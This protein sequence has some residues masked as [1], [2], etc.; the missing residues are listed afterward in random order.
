MDEIT[1]RRLIHQNPELAFEEHNTQRLIVEF[2][3]ELGVNNFVK[4]G[5]GV[6]APV[7][8]AKDEAFI[9]VR[10][11][12]DALPIEEK[13]DYAFRSKN[14]K[15]HACGHDFHIAAVCRVVKRVIQEKL[16]GNFL[17]V[18][19]PAEESGAGAKI[20]VEHILQWDFRV[21]AA[22][23][24]HVTDEYPVGVI[25]SK[26]GVLFSASCEANVRVEGQPV[27]VA[28]HRLGKDALRGAIEFLKGIYNSD[29]DDSLVY[30]GK[31]SAG[32][33][34]NVV[35]GEAL[36]EGTI[37]AR[38]FERVEEI[39]KGMCELGRMVEQETGLKVHVD[40]GAKCPEVKVNED[41]FVILKNISKQY[42]IECLQCEVKLTAEDFGYFSRH[43]PTLM[44]WFG[45]RESS[46]IEGLHSAKFLP[47]DELI[48]LAG[49]FLTGILD[50]LCKD[51][52]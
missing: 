4:I 16:R 21:K 9:I 19:Q 3:R 45:V 49:D 12:M 13:T 18:F 6:L 40:L 22:L 1:L 33:A 44:F 30:F 42:G 32:Q 35:A 17:F 25:A 36:L 23:A 31:L 11:E 2:L 37:R 48:P 51:Q 38:S 24:M 14:G 20:I 29:W 7:V 52:L 27:H 26:P 8:R 39:V 34:R 50:S 43:F 28:M 41:L 5:T 47:S 10:A 15:M 46:H